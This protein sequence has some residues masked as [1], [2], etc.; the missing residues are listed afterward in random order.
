[1]T[2]T[3][4]KSEDAPFQPS[5]SCLENLI[6]FNSTLG[7]LNDDS[8]SSVAESHLNEE[9]ANTLRSRQRNH[10]F[11]IRE[12]HVGEESR[13][14]PLEGDQ[15]ISVEIAVK[16]SIIYHLIKNTFEAQ[17]RTTL[18]AGISTDDTCFANHK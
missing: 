16:K 13:S 4:F 12:S 10:E 18:G 8:L 3:H 2:L 11:Q 15:D 5:E 7:M 17:L 1:M 14:R 9:T 6:T